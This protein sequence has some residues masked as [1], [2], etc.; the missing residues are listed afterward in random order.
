MW[1]IPEKRCGFSRRNKSILDVD[2]LRKEGGGGAFGITHVETP[3]IHKLSPRKFTTQ[4]DMYQ[5][6]KSEGVVVLIEA[7]FV[8]HK[9]W[10][11]ISSVRVFMMNTI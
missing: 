10:H 7:R 3:I 11:M 8:N 2:S 6:Y 1:V 4:N 9:C 5:W